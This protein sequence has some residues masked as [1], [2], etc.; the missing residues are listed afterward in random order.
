MYWI[1]IRRV[2]GEM[3]AGSNPGVACSGVRYGAAVACEFGLLYVMKMVESAAGHLNFFWVASAIL[4]TFC[5]HNVQCFQGWLPKF[6]AQT[7][8]HCLHMEETTRPH[9][10]TRFLRTMLTQML[11]IVPTC[12]QHIV[13]CLAISNGLRVSDYKGN[14]PQAQETSDCNGETIPGR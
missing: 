5:I 6:F 1:S 11:L 10:K 3:V 4:W 8:H 12:I 2:G 14:K 9:L 13:A 7:S